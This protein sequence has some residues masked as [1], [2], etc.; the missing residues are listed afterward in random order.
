MSNNSKAEDGKGIQGFESVLFFDPSSYHEEKD[1][2]SLYNHHRTKLKGVP[3]RPT[4]RSSDTKLSDYKTFISKDLLEHLENSPMKIKKSS[5]AHLR[6]SSD[7][8]SSDEEVQMTKQHKLSQ[9]YQPMGGHMISLEDNKEYLPESSSFEEQSQ[10]Y[11]KLNALNSPDTP[12]GYKLNKLRQ[13]STNPNCAFI[14]KSFNCNSQKQTSTGIFNPTNTLTRNIPNIVPAMD[15]SKQQQSLSN[16]SSPTSN[17]NDSKS[18]MYGKSG[19]ICSMCKNFNYESNSLLT[20]VRSKCNRCG[21]PQSRPG[22][23]LM[24]PF[25]DEQQMQA[26]KPQSPKQPEA[27]DVEDNLFNLNL[28]SFNLQNSIVNFNSSSINDSNSVINSSNPSSEGK[29]NST[30]SDK[31]KKPFVERVGDWVCIKCKNLNFSFRIICNRCQLPKLESDRL[32]EQYMKN[33]MNYVKINEIFQQQIN[34]SANNN[35]SKSEFNNNKQHLRK[36]EKN[37]QESLYNNNY[38]NNEQSG[39]TNNFGNSK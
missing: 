22:S 18:F 30:N 28:Q 6:E 16:K 17:A 4:P 38:F 14:P 32:F 10:A 34:E 9:F 23:E 13:L 5:L 24:K 37:L 27:Y 29:T 36:R 7:N 35:N 31:K 12:Y 19:W 21:K 15:Y 20:L 26:Y 25:Q 3:T 8:C 1:N 33:L 2:H 11:E 39:K